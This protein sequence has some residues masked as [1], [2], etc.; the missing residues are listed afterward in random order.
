MQIDIEK[1][2]KE[3]LKLEKNII[4]KSTLPRLSHRSKLRGFR[5]NPH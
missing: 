3:Q 4:R 1:V 2:K 5:P